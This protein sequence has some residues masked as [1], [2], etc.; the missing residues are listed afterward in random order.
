MQYSGRGLPFEFKIR[1]ENQAYYNG[2]I[3]NNFDY[4]YNLYLVEGTNGTMNFHNGK[5]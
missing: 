1:Y 3:G 4:N 5:L 2:P